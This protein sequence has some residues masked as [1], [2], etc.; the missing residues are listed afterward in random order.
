MAAKGQKAVLKIV[1]K[2]KGKT[3]SL[4]ACIYV[5]GNNLPPVV[6]KKGKRTVVELKERLPVGSEVYVNQKSGYISSEIFFKIVEKLVPY[7]HITSTSPAI[8]VLDGHSSHYTN[9]ELLLHC[10]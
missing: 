1:P 2:E 6:I 3:V 8:L 7:F 9:P 5:S 4:V 10:R